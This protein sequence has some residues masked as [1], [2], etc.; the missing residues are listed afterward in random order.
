M[1]A[2]A[3]PVAPEVRRGEAATTTPGDMR[4][5]WMAQREAFARGAPGYRRRMD[6]LDA[7]R[8][9]LAVREREIV[10]ALSADFGGR[11]REE[12]LLIELFQLTELINHARARLKRWMKPARVG[13]K[14]FLL[15]SRT[16][17]VYQPLGVVG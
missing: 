10:D 8:N 1:S 3:G 11:A 2:H 12:T 5:A 9:E 16:W 6:A 13:S 15:P 14:W 17:V 4:R 7:L